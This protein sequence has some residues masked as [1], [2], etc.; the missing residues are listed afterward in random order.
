MAISRTTFAERLDK[1]NSGETTS[2][3]VPGQGLATLKDE[4]SFLRKAPI[5]MRNISTTRK[6]N[7]LTYL[8]AMAAGAL[9]VMTAR[10]LD[11]HYFDTA[12]AFAAEKGVNAAEILAGIPTTLS[13]AVIISFLAT[14]VFKLGSKKTVPLQA[15]GFLTA[16][17]FEADLVMLAPQVY[18]RFYPPSWVADMMANATLLT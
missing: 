14:L 11:F 1:I 18:A 9:S 4:R 8:V 3:T 5:K 15:A 6:R 2:W 17:L 12:M 10:W 16:V 13:L 7:P